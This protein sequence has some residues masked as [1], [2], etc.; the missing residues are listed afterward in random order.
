MSQTEKPT[1]IGFPDAAGEAT[2]IEAAAEAIAEAAAEAAADGAAEGAWDAGAGDAALEHAETMSAVL[3]ATSRNRL[4][5]LTGSLL[6]ID[7]LLRWID[8]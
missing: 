1:L 3:T 6:L 5:S 4:F 2:A 7:P 8:P